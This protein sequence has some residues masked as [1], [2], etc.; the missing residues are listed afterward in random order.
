M[1]KQFTTNAITK[2]TRKLNFTESVPKIVVTFS[3]KLF[4][5]RV[6]IIVDRFYYAKFIK[7]YTNC[8]VPW[9]GPM[10][11]AKNN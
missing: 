10:N 2:R 6:I 1:L 5:V 7:L 11:L 8:M 9:C 4:L 3:M